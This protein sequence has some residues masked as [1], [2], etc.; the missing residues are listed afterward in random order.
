MPKSGFAANT[1]AK[2]AAYAIAHLLADEAPEQSPAF[3]NTCYALA[4]SDYGFFVSAVYELKDGKIAKK[5]AP[6]LQDLDATVAQRR[7]SAVYQQAWM[8]SFTEDCFA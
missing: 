3:E 5:E 4:G 2:V 7:L 8:K 6:G 1:Q